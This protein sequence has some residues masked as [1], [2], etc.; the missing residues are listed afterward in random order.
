[1]NSCLSQ[2]LIAKGFLQD[3]VSFTE[4]D[5]VF[6]TKFQKNSKIPTQLIVEYK[7]VSNYASEPP[8]TW[9]IC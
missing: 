9:H 4:F 6:N 8:V 2:S 5:T 3:F 7:K 1:M